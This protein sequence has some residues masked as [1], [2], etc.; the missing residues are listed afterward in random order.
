MRGRRDAE[1]VGQVQ[2]PTASILV[3]CCVALGKVAA[4]GRPSWTCRARFD[5]GGGER[6]V[7][8][9]ELRPA[10]KARGLWLPISAVRSLP[11]T[12]LRDPPG[13]WAVTPL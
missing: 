1:S 4:E 7:L 11:V 3:C 12:G 5:P 2:A 10:G 6:S 8:G 13:H 9:P